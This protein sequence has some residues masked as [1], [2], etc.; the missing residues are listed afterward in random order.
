M[1]IFR[2]FV[3]IR[4]S[5]EAGVGG[6]CFRILGIGGNLLFIGNGTVIVRGVK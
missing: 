3:R 2:I 6:F 1:G 4:R 5:V